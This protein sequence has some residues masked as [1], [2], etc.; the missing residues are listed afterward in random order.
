MRLGTHR[1]K[2]AQYP[3]HPIEQQAKSDPAIG[4][5]SVSDINVSI[6]I[7]RLLLASQKHDIADM[8]KIAIDHIE[9]LPLDKVR[10]AERTV[11]MQRIW[12]LE[13]YYCDELDY[14]F[15]ND[16]V[17]YKCYFNL[18]KRDNIW[19]GIT[20]VARHADLM[21]RHIT[22][23]INWLDKGFYVLNPKLLDNAQVRDELYKTGVKGLVDAISGATEILNQRV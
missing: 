13:S 19:V 16:T 12:Q 11:E 5:I 17:F 9:F 1:P 6:T 18:Y 8:H 23:Y 14:E 21:Q 15:F 10:I 22:G 2:V 3:T 4:F 7:C 20:P